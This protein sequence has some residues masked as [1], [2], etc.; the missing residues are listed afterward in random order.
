MEQKIYWVWSQ[1]LRSSILQWTNCSKFP[2]VQYQTELQG[3]SD[4]LFLKQPKKLMHMSI[5]RAFR[6]VT[7]LCVFSVCF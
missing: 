5:M 3:Q 7:H 6:K 1:S 4:S 2:L